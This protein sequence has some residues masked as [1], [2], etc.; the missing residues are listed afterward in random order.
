MQWL[1]VMVAPFLA[2]LALMAVLTASP[3]VTASIIVSGIIAAVLGCVYVCNDER[4][5]LSFTYIGA[6]LQRE[7][8]MKLAKANQ[9]P[10]H[11]ED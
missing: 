2:V 5:F 6:I 7:A 10:E 9:G 3:R 1:L 11:V 4:G 8:E